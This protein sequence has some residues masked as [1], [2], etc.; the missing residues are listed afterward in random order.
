MPV[1]AY[2]E[3]EYGAI[4]YGRGPLFLKVLS[5]KMGE[6]KFDQFLKDYFTTYSWKVATGEDFQALAE[7]TCSCDLDRLFKEWVTIE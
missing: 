5:D 2:T 7:T 6:A 4:V 3:L 1:E